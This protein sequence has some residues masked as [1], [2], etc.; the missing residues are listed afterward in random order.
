VD[1]TMP[2]SVFGEIRPGSFAV[3]AGRTTRDRLVRDL[4]RHALET[5]GGDDFR[6]RFTRAFAGSLDLLFIVECQPRR[7]HTVAIDRIEKSGQ[8]I[9]KLQLEY[10]VYLADCVERV[11]RRLQARARK[12]V[13]K[14]V[15]TFPTSYHWMGATRMAASEREG[16]VDVNLQYHGVENLHVLSCS[17]YP[18]SSSANPTLT[19][20]ALA[21]RLGDHLAG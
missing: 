18:S 20:A 13:I 3:P 16:C 14:Y 12:A 1:D 5:P 9:P 17:V 7:E 10:P 11:T 6:H 4:I 8:A 21:L 19:L 2:V 15:N